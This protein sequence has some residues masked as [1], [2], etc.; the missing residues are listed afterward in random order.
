VA[1]DGDVADLCGLGHGLA[2]LLGARWGSGREA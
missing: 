2:L 1:D